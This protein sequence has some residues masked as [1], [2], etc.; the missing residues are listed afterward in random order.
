MKNLP[1]IGKIYNCFDDGKIT[2]SRLYTVKILEIIPFDKIDE[3]TLNNWKK[4]VENCHW[5][6]AKETDYFIKA[7]GE[8]K[9]D[10]ISIFVRTLNGGWFSIGSFLN[11]GRLDVDGELTELLKTR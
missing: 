11:S 7:T 5:L 1:E 10:D 3:E 6:Y 9:E 4:E 2:K 8:L